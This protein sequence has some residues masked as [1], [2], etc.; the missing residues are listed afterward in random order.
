MEKAFGLL[1]AG[2]GIY[3]SMIGLTLICFALYSLS[4]MQDNITSNENLRTRWNAKHKNVQKSRRARLIGKANEDM[5]PEQ[6]EEHSNLISD[7]QLERDRLPGCCEK[8]N[9]FFFGQIYPSHMETY[10]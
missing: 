4:L 3:A 1:S 6:L 2:V 8:I 5:S 7:M 10:L 9:Y